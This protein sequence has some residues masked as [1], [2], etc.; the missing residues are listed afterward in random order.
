MKKEGEIVIFE[1]AFR[2]KDH[3]TIGK[4]GLITLR[5]LLSIGRRNHGKFLRQ[6]V[7]F[8]P[9]EELDTFSKHLLFADKVI[10]K[11]FFGAKKVTIEV[12]WNRWA[13]IEKELTNE[14]KRLNK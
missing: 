7:D 11:L 8:K 14:M 1:Y 9:R 13:E 12:D 10:E 5:R 2:E 6:K 4:D 3:V